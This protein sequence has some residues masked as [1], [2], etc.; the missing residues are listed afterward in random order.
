[1]ADIHSLIEAALAA[2]LRAYAPYSQFQVGAAL[3]AHDG[4]V[5]TGCNV[6]NAS[7]GLCNCAER[8]AFFG[9]IAAGYG[10]G[11]FSH[12]AV[13]G[14]T[15]EPISPCGACRQVMIELG[16]PSLIV[17]QTNLDGEIHETTAAALLPGAFALEPR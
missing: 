8:S 10:P 15:D 3:L 12:L 11:D 1:M 17:V 13:V 6:E 14:D 5:F 9:A 7:Y 16:G 4:R 2:R